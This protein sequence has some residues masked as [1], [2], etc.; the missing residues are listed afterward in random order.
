[1][2]TALQLFENNGYESTSISKIALTAG[3]SKGLMYNYF[4]SKVALF[5]FNLPTQSIPNSWR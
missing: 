2:N 3:V 4:P 1:M 5:F